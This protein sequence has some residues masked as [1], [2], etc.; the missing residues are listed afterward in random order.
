MVDSALFRPVLLLPT[1]DNART[2]GA[3]LASAADLGRPVVVVNDGSTDETAAVIG[4]FVAERPGVALTRLDHDRN[5]GKGAA[6]R[7]GFGWA[8]AQ[9]FTHAVTMDTDGQHTAEDAGRLLDAA[10]AAPT[11]LVLGCRDQSDPAYPSASR[12]GR[13]FS[14]LCIF[15]ASGRRVE[16]SQCG[17]RVY[18]LGLVEAV[19]CRAGRYGYEAEILTRSGWA[20]CPLVQTPVRV[21]YPEGE[22]RV[23]HFRPWR[24]SLHGA[25]LHLRLWLRAVLPLPFPKWPPPP[26]EVSQATATRRG[27][28]KW[29]DYFR[30]WFRGVWRWVDPREL[31]RAARRDRVSQMSVALGLG[32]GV[33][34]A[35]LPVYPVQTL[36][37]MYLAKR[38]HLHPVSTVAGSQAAFPP[39]GLLLIF[40]AIYLG[41]VVLTGDPPSWSDF[42]GLGALSFAEIRGLM[43]E[44]FLSWWI[45]GL[46]IGS[47]MGIATFAVGLGLLKWVPVEHA[48]NVSEE[49]LGERAGG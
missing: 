49:A 44:Y 22:A 35:N 29:S 48:T 40:A 7:T 5:R 6:L 33:F 41:H 19:R 34:V 13:L 10:A 24:D 14:N 46:A 1:Y 45:G 20:G 39:F 28:R 42:S 31:V 17:L 30:G 2:L 37:A 9:G 47:V 15:V 12:T 38:L 23:S 16:D 26:P 3:V 43:H 11:A 25:A 8:S 32:V 36:V 18:P 21:I 4:R 27:R